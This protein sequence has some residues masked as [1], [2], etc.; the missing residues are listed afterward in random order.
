MPS[1]TNSLSQHHKNLEPRTYR[2]SRPRL[3]IYIYILL[4]S[5]R[6]YTILTI[7]YFSWPDILGSCLCESYVSLISSYN[8][9]S[10]RTS[11][12][13]RCRPNTLFSLPHAKGAQQQRYDVG[14]QDSLNFQCSWQSKDFGSVAKCSVH[15]VWRPLH[16]E[17]RPLPKILVLL[18]F[19]GLQRPLSLSR[20]L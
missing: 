14:K 7:V 19:L 6:Y 2:G 5:I 12:F 18:C 3:Y 11:R 16:L 10:I 15:M 8:C 9:T 17:P 1:M 20:R 4:D 13:F